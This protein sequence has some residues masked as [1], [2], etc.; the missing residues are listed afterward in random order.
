M[1]GQVAGWLGGWVVGWPGSWAESEQIKIH[2]F[3]TFQQKKL[4]DNIKSLTS[5][6][7]AIRMYEACGVARRG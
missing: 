2:V 7:Y 1:C 4:N 6:F 3:Q 5:C